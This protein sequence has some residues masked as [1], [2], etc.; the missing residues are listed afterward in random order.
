MRKYLFV[1]LVALVTLFVSFLPKASVESTQQNLRFSPEIC[2][3]SANSTQI[4][5]AGAAT[6]VQVFRGKESKVSSMKKTF[7]I[8]QPQPNDWMEISESAGAPVLV[9]R[10]SGLSLLACPGIAEPSWF[11]GGASDVSSQDQL[12]LAN[13]GASPATLLVKMWSTE[14]RAV[15]TTVTVNG[16]TSKIVRLDTLAPGVKAMVLYIEPQVGRVSISLQSKRQTGLKSS[17]A[18]YIS[19]SAAPSL[20]QVIPVVLGIGKMPVVKSTT[21]AKN[22]GKKATVTPKT[23]AFTRTLRVLVPGDSPATFTAT[24]LTN[25]GTYIPV[26]LDQVSLESGR[27]REFNFTT[28]VPASLSALHITS[29]VPI[30]ASVNNRDVDYAWSPAVSTLEKESSVLI[31]PKATLALIGSGSSTIAIIT[32]GSKGATSLPVSSEKLATWVN[33]SKDWSL[34]YISSDGTL[35]GSV[36]VSDVS[37]SAILPIR[38]RVKVGSGSLPISDLSITRGGASLPTSG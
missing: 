7:T 35:H 25:D 2:P 37:G 13:D 21:K 18:D 36:V 20:D 9:D 28:S 33:G 24:L 3:A 5:V 14:D 1:A 23:I 15:E 38:N 16:R 6:K 22:K 12:V 30:V 8:L 26:G 32:S 34:V 29:D 31:P 27:V 10:T 17:G 11:V 4:V 19:A